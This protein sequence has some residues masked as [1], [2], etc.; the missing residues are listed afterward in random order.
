MPKLML[1]EEVYRDMSRELRN[2]Y[3]VWLK[4]LRR[5]IADGKRIFETLPANIGSKLSGNERSQ[6]GQ[7]CKN[8][9]DAVRASMQRGQGQAPR[10]NGQ[11]PRGNGQ[12]PAQHQRGQAQGGQAPAQHQR[13]QAQGGQAPAQHRQAPA[14]AAGSGGSGAQNFDSVPVIRTIDNFKLHMDREKDSAAGRYP[15]QELMDEC[16]LAE[17]LDE[18]LTFCRNVE[19]RQGKFKDTT[20]SSLP[21]PNWAKLIVMILHGDMDEEGVKL[22]IGR[23]ENL[24]DLIMLYKLQ[25]NPNNVVG[26]ERNS[27]HRMMIY[28]YV[29]SCMNGLRKNCV[30]LLTDATAA[31]SRHQHDEAAVQQARQVLPQPVSS[32][33][34]AREGFRGMTDAAKK[35]DA[36][37][38]ALTKTN[39][40]TFIDTFLEDMDYESAIHNKSPVDV[41]F[42]I[43]SGIEA[44][45]V[46][47]DN[48][49]QMFVPTEAFKKLLTAFKEEKKK[50]ARD[51]ERAPEGS[52]G[53]YE[54]TKAAGGTYA[55]LPDTGDDAATAGGPRVGYAGAVGR[56]A[57]PPSMPNAV[58]V[59]RRAVAGE[60]GR[61]KIHVPL[62]FVEPLEP[63]GG[64]RNPPVVRGRGGAAIGG[65]QG[66]SGS[67]TLLP[68]GRGGG[69]GRGA[70]FAYRSGRIVGDD[71]WHRSAFTSDK[72]GEEDVGG[73]FVAVKNKS[74]PLP[75]DPGYFGP[76]A[77]GDNG[78][79]DQYQSP[80]KLPDQ[81]IEESDVVAEGAGE[82][83]RSSRGTSNLPSQTV[84]EDDDWRKGVAGM[85]PSRATWIP[86]EN[87]PGGSRSLP[88]RLKPKASG[89]VPSE[90]ASD[91]K[92]DRSPASSSV[93]SSSVRREDSTPDARGSAEPR[94]SSFLRDPR[95]ARSVTGVEDLIGD[96]EEFGGAVREIQDLLGPSGGV[97]DS[98]RRTEP[99]SG[100]LVERLWGAISDVMGSWRKRHPGATVE[101]FEE[102]LA[103][104][105]IEAGARLP[106]DQKAAMKAEFHSMREYE[107]LSSRYS[108]E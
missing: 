74:K 7:E 72:D 79:H 103:E 10:G 55:R 59:P 57:P 9:E 82:R 66:G 2:E 107:R 54:E 39:F 23:D 75:S 18:L 61:A 95:S 12:A 5:T 67:G 37:L 97:E 60:G 16:G 68:V 69:R 1:P 30:K 28:S 49:K 38:P 94:D 56:H 40:E 98:L 87:R 102:K 93:A 88:D 29:L 34:E 104:T 76:L 36:P 64:A 50:A 81:S 71:G 86:P 70:S 96:E 42:G 73:E 84:D 25:T 51:A 41:A 14:R 22:A 8:Y 27:Q 63:R 11:A 53:V 105:E 35:G 45:N 58:G 26:V 62:P 46:G 101:E 65:R 15:D 91:V 44:V 47:L 20:E 33:E 43:L 77:P 6:F 92:I 24:G 32:V 89:P 31:T 4:T 17:V 108:L 106:P 90:A 80:P 21:N 13:G 99:R 52:T 19:L 78:G 3:G 83:T 85:T 100:L 48:F